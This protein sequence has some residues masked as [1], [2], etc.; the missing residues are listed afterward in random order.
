M[1]TRLFLFLFLAFALVAC[2]PTGPTGH[3]A[4]VITLVSPNGEET[5]ESLY[6]VNIPSSLGGHYE[7]WCSAKNN[8]ATDFYWLSDN[9]K[10]KGYSASL[11]YT[12]GRKSIEVSLIDQPFNGG[13]Y[14][15]ALADVNL[16]TGKL[17]NLYLEKKIGSEAD[18]RN[19]IISTNLNDLTFIVNTEAALTAKS[20]YCK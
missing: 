9:L 2:A 20:Y 13:T 16:T 12:P 15:N 11:M 10:F 6:N 18:L 17:S 8:P 5:G 7:L 19:Y 3:W 1:K 4:R 14:V